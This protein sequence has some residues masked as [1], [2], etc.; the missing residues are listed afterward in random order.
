MAGRIDN[1]TQAAA[2]AK[3][4]DASKHAAEIRQHL[5]QIINSPA[6]KGSHRSQEFLRY[7]VERSLRGEFSEL[8][9][10]NIGTELFGRPAS[11]DTAADAIV[12]VTAS[13]VRKRL[14]QYYWK[15]EGDSDLRVDL[16]SGSYIPEFQ[17]KLSAEPGD[18]KPVACAEETVSENVSPIPPVSGRWLSLK[19]GWHMLLIPATLLILVGGLGGWAIGQRAD[20]V[21][22]SHDIMS[23]AFQG[24]PGPIEV[25]VSDEALVLSQVLL[26]HNCT[27]QEYESLSY[28]N[29]PGFEESDSTRRLRNLLASRQI[30]NIGDLQNAVR[31]SERLHARNFQVVI[32]HAR[33]YHARDFRS[34]NFIILGASFSN[35]WATLFVPLT[36]NFPREDP[37]PPH[38]VP[39]WLN[40]HPLPGEPARFEVQP[41][42]NGR[43]TITYA[44]VSLVENS[45]HTGR[46]ILVAGQSLSA[47]DMATEFLFQGELLSEVRRR[48]GLPLTGPLPALEMVLR[49]TELNETGES[50]ELAACRKLAGQLD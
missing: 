37:P 3:I 31:I 18:L 8:R 49:V 4:V 21:P 19:S 50:V 36:S 35:P 33:E 46:A 14:L 32:R 6:F 48:L 12:R 23:C 29:L 13:D 10:R 43:K 1:T 45:F 7:V 40:R 5:E 34:G 22:I 41:G 30:A 28:W 42:E 11:Y 44:R 25:I 15:V 9:E 20:A 17:W 39:A 24:M 16:P 47:T 27:L 38:K 2:I 26:R